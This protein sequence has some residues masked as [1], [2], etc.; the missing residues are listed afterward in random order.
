MSYSRPY[1]L[2]LQHNPLRAK[3]EQR[4]RRPHQ[5]RPRKHLSVARS[6]RPTMETRKMKSSASQRS[7]RRPRPSLQHQRLHQPRVA[8]EL[9]PKR[10]PHRQTMSFRQSL[11]TV[12]PLLVHVVCDDAPLQ[13]AQQS[14]LPLIPVRTTT[15]KKSGLT[16]VLRTETKV[17]S[18]SHKRCISD[19]VD[20]D[21]TTQ[22]YIQ[23]LRKITYLTPA[24]SSSSRSHGHVHHS[25]NIVEWDG[26]AFEQ[27]ALTRPCGF[28][29]VRDSAFT[30]H[31]RMGRGGSCSAYFDSPL[32][33]RVGARL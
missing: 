20:S 4:L 24:P 19:Y 28:E 30:G 25:L 9:L 31:H 27:H 32:R 33:V 1:R 11:R 22:S 7:A 10:L 13:Q 18:E 12:A 5:S 16:Y 15:L 3:P 2:V 6:A 14:T 26:A 23:C 8:P 29:L 17:A 21:S